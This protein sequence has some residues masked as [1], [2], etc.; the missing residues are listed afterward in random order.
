MNFK[1]VIFIFNLICIK[2]ISSNNQFDVKS[3][4]EDSEFNDYINVLMFNKTGTVEYCKF[5]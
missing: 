5:N 1:L 3:N 4:D 2:L